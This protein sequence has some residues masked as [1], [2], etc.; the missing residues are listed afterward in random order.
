MPSTATT[1]ENPTKADLIDADKT[2]FREKCGCIEFIEDTTTSRGYTVS[3]DKCEKT[4]LSKKIPL[5]SKNFKKLSC[6]QVAVYGP[7]FERR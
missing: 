3:F 5:A 6:Q 1:I 7:L 2:L 4:E